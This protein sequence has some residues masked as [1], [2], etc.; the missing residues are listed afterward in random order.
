M[1]QLNVMSLDELLGTLCSLIPLFIERKQENRS[2][3]SH[4]VAE[5]IIQDEKYENA[6]QC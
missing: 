6:L 3:L 5:G 2:S 4:K 1:L